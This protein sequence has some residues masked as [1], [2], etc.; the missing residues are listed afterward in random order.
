M[1]VVVPA[2]V[3][4]TVETGMWLEYTCAHVR[5]HVSVT[6][7]PYYSWGIDITLGTSGNIFSSN[8]VS[9]NGA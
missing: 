3:V 4:A 5:G 2:A 9:S 7:L 6:D 1:A 8:N